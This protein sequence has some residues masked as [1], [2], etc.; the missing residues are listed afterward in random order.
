MCRRQGV[1]HADSRSVTEQQ[2]VL[3]PVQPQVSWAWMVPLQA[4]NQKF[5]WPRTGERQPLQDQLLKPADQRSYTYQQAQQ[6]IG[7]ELNA[8]LE[9]AHPEGAAA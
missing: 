7:N 5:E 2:A 6:R 1:T 8:A 3:P 9:D 4:R